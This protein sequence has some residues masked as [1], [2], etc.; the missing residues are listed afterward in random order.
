MRKEIL[1][2][3]PETF[4]LEKSSVIGNA[5]LISFVLPMRKGELIIILHSHLALF[6]NTARETGVCD[7]T[8]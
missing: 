5:S 7:W 4:E 1:Q 2:K 8:A 3:N 6:M